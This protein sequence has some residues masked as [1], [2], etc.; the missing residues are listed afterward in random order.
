M[1]ETDTSTS[2]STLVSVV[3]PTHN[4]A[5]LLSRAIQSVLDQTHRNLEILVVDDASTDGTRETVENIKGVRIRYIRQPRSQGAAAARNTGIQN[6]G[7]EYVAFLDDDDEWEPQKLEEQIKILRRHPAAM[8]AYQGEE[9]SVARVYQMK[10]TIDLPEL[11]KGFFRGGSASALI[12]RTDLLRT[13]LFDETLPRF[14]D[15]DLCIRLAQ[16]A[17]IGY[18]PRPLVRYNDGD[19]ARISNKA[20]AL[21]LAAVEGEL[22]MVAKHKEFFGKRWYRFHVCRY[23]LQNFRHR[24]NKIGCVV[25]VCRNYGFL[26]FMRAAAN[27]IYDR[28][29]RKM[30]GWS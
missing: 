25:Y 12:A 26:P 9:R 24:S 3:I 21:S 27:L 6:A 16:H 5:D 11:K 28:S 4:R 18:T 29:V 19:H 14:Q 17:S 7:G 8:C 30:L 1:L 23:L 2:A 15:W 20:R 10:P 22:R 13:V